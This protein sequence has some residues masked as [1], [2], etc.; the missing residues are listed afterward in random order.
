MAT[1]LLRAGWPQEVRGAA[2]PPAASAASRSRAFPL[3]HSPLIFVFEKLYF[4][5]TRDLPHQM[6]FRLFRNR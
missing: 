4:F 5:A 1:P 2:M 3:Y 6:M